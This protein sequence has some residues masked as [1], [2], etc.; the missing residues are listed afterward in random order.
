MGREYKVERYIPGFPWSAVFKMARRLPDGTST[1]RDLSGNVLS[2]RASVGPLTVGPTVA[3]ESD[4]DGACLVR[5]S[6]TEVQ[7]GALGAGRLDLQVVRE[8]PGP[9]R[10]LIIAAVSPS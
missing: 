10:P 5:V 3:I 8:S 4:E 2:G 1:P 9:R 7:T 6:L